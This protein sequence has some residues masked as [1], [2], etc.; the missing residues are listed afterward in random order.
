MTAMMNTKILLTRDDLPR[1]GIRIPSQS[2]RGG[3]RTRKRR[4]DHR[5]GLGRCCLCY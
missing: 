4:E 3:E 5:I 2:D 1:L